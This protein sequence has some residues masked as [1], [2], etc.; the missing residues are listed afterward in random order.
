MKQQNCRM[1][2]GESTHTW[3]K[4]HDN[5]CKTPS[6]LKRKDIRNENLYPKKCIPQ[7]G[8]HL[9][10]D[11]SSELAVGLPPWKPCFFSWLPRKGGKF[12]WN[13]HVIHLVD[14]WYLLL[15]KNPT[16]ADS[17]TP[18][19]SAE[20]NRETFKWRNSIESI[21]AISVFKAIPSNTPRCYQVTLFR[22]VSMTTWHRIGNPPR[23]HRIKER[24]NLNWPHKKKVKLVIVVCCMACLLYTWKNI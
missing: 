14:L 8:K 24:E 19:L 22:G 5:G 16:K 2:G 12:T 17:Q 7:N 11:I 10:N 18:T 1:S 21:S 15:P 20:R 4:L 3:T 13:H 23:I 6:P 9:A